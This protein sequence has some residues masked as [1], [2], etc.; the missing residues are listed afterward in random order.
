MSI[1]LFRCEGG[2][3]VLPNRNL[4][5]VSREDGGNLI[6]NPPREVWERSELSASELTHWSFLVSAAG[7]AMIDTLP[8]LDGGCVNYWEAGNWSLNENANPAGP[9]NAPQHR[10]VHLHLLGRSRNAMH[11]D[12]KWGEAPKFPD[13]KDRFEWA[14]KFQ[15]L[16]PEECSRIVLR[17]RTILSLK[18]G[19]NGGEVGVCGSCAYPAIRPKCEECA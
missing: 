10:R 19:I 2:D 17:M 12:L 15:R 9:K 14:A 8:Q 3:L 16:T 6:V 4:V 18:F 13:F 11:P 5:L 7:R 1:V